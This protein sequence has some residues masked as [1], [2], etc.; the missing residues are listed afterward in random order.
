MKT[1]LLIVLVW[2]ITAYAA[3]KHKESN[4]I[5]EQK[6]YVVPSNWKRIDA[7]NVEFHIPSNLIEKEPR[8]PLMPGS[9]I[10]YYGNE[11]IWL[12]F[13]IQ[14]KSASSDRFAKERD[15]QVEQ[16]IVDGKQAEISIF[17]GT[18][19]VNEAE[20]KNY[21]ASLDVPQIQENTKNLLMWAYSKS[22]EDR[23][24]VIK[25]FKSVRFL[26]E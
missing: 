21:V 13:T 8:K 26:K 23:E 24:T 4:N 17:T 7:S 20:G 2:T 15:F 14:S 11:N 5:P 22:P 9:T 19:M 3:C 1:L 12:V 18:E 16:T 25:I 10:K 6:E